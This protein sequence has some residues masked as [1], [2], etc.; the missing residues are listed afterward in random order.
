M[1]DVF[2]R[3]AWDLGFAGRDSDMTS[4]KGT[5]SRVTPI[6]YWFPGS[7]ASDRPL[8]GRPV[9]AFAGSGTSKEPWFPSEMVMNIGSAKPLWL[10]WKPHLWDGRLIA[11]PLRA[12]R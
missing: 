3:L 11:S 9:Q 2:K 8:L 7:L 10:R 5:K 4:R 1:V 12:S 6:G